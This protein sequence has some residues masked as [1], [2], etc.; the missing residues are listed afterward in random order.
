MKKKYLVLANG[1]IFEGESFGFDGTATGEIVFNTAAVGYTE[2]L[3]DPAYYGQIVVQTF[4]LAGNYGI[5]VEDFESEKPR[6][7][8]YIV[9]EFCNEPS[10][11]RAEITLDKFLKDNEIVGLCGI[12]TRELTEI[13]RDNGVMPACIADE[14]TPELI[15]NLK[16]F[17]IT[18]ALKNTA[19]EVKTYPAEGKEK[20]HVVMIDYGAERSTVEMLTSRG[21]RVT[22]VPYTASAEEVLA[23]KPD[24]IF[25]STGAGDP[26]ENAECVATIKELVGQ[27]PIFG[28]GLGHQL[29]ALAQGAKVE[30]LKCGHRGAGQPVK[31]AVTGKVFITAQNHG[32]A[33]VADSLPMSAALMY[34]NVNDNTC[35]GIDYPSVKAFTLQFSPE[36]CPAPTEAMTLT[37]KFC[38]LMEEE[39][40]IKS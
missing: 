16:N 32:Y 34:T 18:D 22:G 20:Y 5:T 15:Q 3:T 33:V 19:H 8:G 17:K 37:D 23:L 38:E 26:N 13:I 24:G 11:F 27:K 31:S 14:V 7:F 40:A 36:A 30:K 2:T 35:E 29:F 21:C 9:R 10:N 6:L 12:D 1:K 39:N 25:L 28:I 4:P